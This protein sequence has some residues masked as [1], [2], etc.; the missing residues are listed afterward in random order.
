MDSYPILEPS[1]QN[2]NAPN[3]WTKA[4]RIEKKAEMERQMSK[5][6]RR[7]ILSETPPQINAPTHRPR[8][9]I[10]PKNFGKNVVNH[11]SDQFFFNF[12][13]QAKLI[14]LHLD[15]GPAGLMEE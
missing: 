7:P 15:R 6:W 10:E 9:A 1:L 14:F 3:P 12:S 5:Q 13:Y 2:R 11:N 8:Y 4:E